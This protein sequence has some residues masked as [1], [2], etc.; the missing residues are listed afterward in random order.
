MRHV[1]RIRCASSFI[2]S[3][4]NSLITSLATLASVLP[5]TLLLATALAGCSNGSTTASGP[6]ALAEAIVDDSVITTK[7]KI[8]LLE[9]TTLKGANILVEI[10]HRE[11]VMTGSVLNTTQKDHA[12]QIA[13]ALN[14]VRTVDNKLAASK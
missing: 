7:L 8:A 13:Q 11:V 9:D 10:C 6:L 3:T 5:G 14:G 12:A 2:N 1:A 4:G